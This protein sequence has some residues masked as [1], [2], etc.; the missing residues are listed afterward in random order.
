MADTNEH[1]TSQLERV[2]LERQ[3]QHAQRLEAIGRLAGGV[4]HDFNNLLQVINGY[5]ELV[6]LGA[7]NDGVSFRRELDAIAEAGRRGATLTNQLLAFSR[8]ATSEATTV[9]I[10]DA[11]QSAVTLIE[12][13]IGDDIRVVV[14]LSDDAGHVVI[15]P[16][17]IGQVIMNLGINA[18]DAMPDG[19]LLTIETMA[20]DL[21]EHARAERLTPG[22]YTMVAV[23]DTGVGMSPDVRDRLFEPF[24][25]T[26][27]ADD[28]TGL[29]LPIVSGIV[30]RAGGHVTAYSE[31]GE[32]AVFK[33][34]LPRQDL[35]PEAI[36]TSPPTYEM[37]DASVL[38]VEDEPGV[39]DLL[40]NMLGRLG[41]AVTSVASPDEAV[42]LA[43]LDHQLLITDVMMP[44]MTGPTLARQL[45]VCRA[46]LRVLYISGYTGTAMTERSILRA[47]DAFLAKPF[48]MASLAERVGE[49]LGQRVQNDQNTGTSSTDTTP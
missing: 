14:S 45:R 39:R 5:V 15:D 11:V 12:R 22:R 32:G 7:N 41:Y 27:S 35:S 4:A 19:G 37:G 31:L 46:D 2:S 10:N 29:G 28:G 49:L 17:Q 8:D 21:D 40:T 6:Q 23:S 48:T 43:D 42:A 24:F 18:R 20:V 47:D 33:V 3:L 16:H 26:K 9:D 38:V 13:L 30:R 34:Y 1:S 36:D 44:T 25:T